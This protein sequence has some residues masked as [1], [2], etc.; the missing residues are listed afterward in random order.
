MGRHVVT[1]GFH[2][3]LSYWSKNS[4]WVACKISGL[5]YKL[6]YS[7]SIIASSTINVTGS[8]GIVVNPVTWII[9]SLYDMIVAF[10][11]KIA[12]KESF[13]AVI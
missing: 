6:I 10:W 11:P 1:T 13:I 4:S 9:F 12:G 5:R 7:Y 8:D 2:K 3:D